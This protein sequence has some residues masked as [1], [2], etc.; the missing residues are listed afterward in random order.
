M[1]RK[2]LGTLFLAIFFANICAAQSNSLHVFTNRN[3]IVNV[4]DAQLSIGLTNSIVASGSTMT[5]TGRIKNTST[6]FF[7]I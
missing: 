2:T 3:V 1:T 5:L 7:Y 6:N 4:C